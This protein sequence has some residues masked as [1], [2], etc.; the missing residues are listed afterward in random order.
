MFNLIHKKIVDT[1][2]QKIADAVLDY[3]NE[4]EENMN[5]LKEFVELCDD[6]FDTYFINET[7]QEEVDTL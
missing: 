1:I 5:N 4:S 6:F 3:A 2:G 7:K